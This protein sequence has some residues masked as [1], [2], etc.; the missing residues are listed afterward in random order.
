ML[1]LLE[2]ANELRVAK[3]RK[4]V[5]VDLSPGERPDDDHLASLMVSRWGKLRAP[6]LRVGDTFV[7]GY[8]KDILASVFGTSGES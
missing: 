6:S 8:N 5:T 4:V 2:G 7:V 1:A 3:G